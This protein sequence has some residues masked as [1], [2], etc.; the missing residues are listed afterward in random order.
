V[1]VLKLTFTLKATFSFFLQKT[2][3]SKYRGEE[4]EEVM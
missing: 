3:N 1:C 2:A 4:E